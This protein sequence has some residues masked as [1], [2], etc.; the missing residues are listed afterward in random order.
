MKLE[1]NGEILS[2]VVSTYP[3]G[4]KA[5]ALYTQDGCP[6]ASISVNLPTTPS[7][8]SDV[9]YVKDWSENELLVIG[10]ITKKYIK[11]VDDIP[12]V[13]S[14]FIENVYAYRLTNE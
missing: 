13:S 1:I 14:G 2:L 10:L 6:Y 3:N 4:G 5:V 9:F 12:S 7:L 8:P 11:K